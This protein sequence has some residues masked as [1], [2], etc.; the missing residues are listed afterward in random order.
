VRWP[1]LP[2]LVRYLLRELLVPLS[3]WVVFLFLLLFVMQ[4]SG[5]RRCCSARR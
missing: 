2:L 4:F 5:H 3:L 1:E